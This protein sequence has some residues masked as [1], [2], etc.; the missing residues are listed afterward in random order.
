[1]IRNICIFALY[2]RPYFKIS[3]DA[4][5]NKPRTRGPV[6]LIL[7]LNVY[8]AEASDTLFVFAAI[9]YICTSLGSHQAM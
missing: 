7:C 4:L 6:P 1:M 9:R 2:S 3:L 5:D 8:I